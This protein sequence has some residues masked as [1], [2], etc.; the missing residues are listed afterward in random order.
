MLKKHNLFRIFKKNP[1]Q[2]RNIGLL[3]SFKK[4]SRLEIRPIRNRLNRGVPVYRII[5][6]ALKIYL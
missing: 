6:N 3:Y 1:V 5:V 4:P 2:I